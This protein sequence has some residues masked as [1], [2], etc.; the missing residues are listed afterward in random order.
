M[1]AALVGS[2]RKSSEPSRSIVTP[3]LEG[4][5][6]VSFTSCVLTAILTTFVKGKTTLTPGFRTLGETLPKKS[7]TPTCPAGMTLTGLPRRMTRTTATTMARLRRLRP[8][9]GGP[10]TSISLGDMAPPFVERYPC[11]VYGEAGRSNFK[12]WILDFGFWIEHQEGLW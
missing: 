9:P 12:F 6:A 7:L 1:S 5:S 2:S 3:S 4:T 8:P 11:L 10:L